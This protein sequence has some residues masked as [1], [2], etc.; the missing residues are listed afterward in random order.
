MQFVDPRVDVFRDER[1]HGHEGCNQS[2][3]PDGDLLEASGVRPG[4]F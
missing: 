3:R 1:R 2:P 4:Y